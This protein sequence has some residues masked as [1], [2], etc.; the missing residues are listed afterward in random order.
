MHTVLDLVQ[1]KRVITIVRG[2]TPEAIDGL[3]AALVAGGIAM[4]E[5][6]FD[7]TRPET[8]QDTAA[9][10]RLLATR[11]AGQV[12]PGA[13][14]VLT[15]E[16]AEMVHDAGAQYIISPNVDEAVIARTKALG[17]A[18]F[19]GALTPTEVVAAWQAGADAVKVFPAGNLGPGYISALKAPLRHIPL[20]AVGGIPEERAAEYIA[21]GAIGLGIG[22]NLVKADW[23]AAGEWA[24][25]TALARAYCE[26]AGAR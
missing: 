1:E 22:G 4:I 23:I 5:V 11:Y 7:Q 8:W 15:P 14:T 21:A 19:P 10:I 13:G 16:Q 2:L 17:M 25:I 26:A 18:S 12:S 9:A 20:M 6:T 3:A 24:R